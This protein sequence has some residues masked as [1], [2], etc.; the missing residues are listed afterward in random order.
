MNKGNLMLSKTNQAYEYIK[1]GLKSGRWTFG[2]QISVVEIANELGFSRRPVIDALKKLEAEY[3]LEIIPQTG[4]RVKSYSQ[5]EMFDH[6]LT[7]MALEGMAAYLAAQRREDHEVNEL[8]SINEQLRRVIQEN[9]SKE[10]Y[11][12]E[13]RRLHY[14][15][16]QMSRSKKLLDMTQS[17]WD[18]N[19]FFLVNVSL[20]QQDLSRTIIEHEMIIEKIAKK[21][22]VGARTL[23]ENHIQTFASLVKKNPDVH[24]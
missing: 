2:D 23:M 16:L 22:P 24:H 14:V 19:D 12:Q 10:K 11:F 8:I 6:F 4:C 3:F 1:E 13:N 21:D 7:V 5:D 18:L 15:I 20:F 17:Q 9:F